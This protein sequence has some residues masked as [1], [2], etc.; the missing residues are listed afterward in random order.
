M[1]RATDMGRHNLGKRLI[2]PQVVGSRKNNGQA[3]TALAREEQLTKQ[4]ETAG[5]AHAV[6]L[7]VNI[8]QAECFG[9]VDA[10][11]CCFVNVKID[12]NIYGSV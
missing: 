12:A 11:G 2:L 8:V 6:I 7:L 4:L 3:L 5:D 1:S 9:K 10:N